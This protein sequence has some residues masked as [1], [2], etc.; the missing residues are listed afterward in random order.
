ML[1]SKK[2]SKGHSAAVLGAHTLR[3]GIGT[4]QMIA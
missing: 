2:Q 4:V 3:T 1:A